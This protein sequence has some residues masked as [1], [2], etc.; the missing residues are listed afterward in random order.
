MDLPAGT[1][2]YRVKV[3]RDLARPYHCAVHA[4]HADPPDGRRSWPTSAEPD[5]VIYNAGAVSGQSATPTGDLE[6][7][8][9][10][11]LRDAASS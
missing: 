2:K 8:H 9:R 5:Y 7:Q 1:R 6:D 3:P 4:Q 10:L 11:S